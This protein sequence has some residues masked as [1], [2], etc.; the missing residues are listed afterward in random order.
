MYVPS[1]FEEKSTDVLH[2][3][4]QSQPFGT[5]VTVGDGGIEANHLPFELD[6]AAGEF[7]TLRA[8]VAR[9]NPVWKEFSRDVDALVIFEGANAYVS[10][11][12]YAAKQEHGKVVPTWNYMTVHAYGLMRIVDDPVWLKSL[13]GRLTDRHEAGRFAPWKLADAPQDYIDKMLEAIVG[14]EIPVARLLGKWKVSQ[15][16]SGADRA[17]VAEGL[18]AEGGEDA[19]AMADAVVSSRM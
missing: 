6:S 4:I 19:S 10:P 17:G 12:W 2:G 8:H 13:I 9:A 5:L 16:R 7:G 15:N 11:S 3:L 14:I 1:H 18:R